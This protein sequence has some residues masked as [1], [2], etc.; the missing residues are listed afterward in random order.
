MS[1]S[2]SSQEDQPTTASLLESLNSNFTPSTPHVHKFR[3]EMCKN[4]EMY[5]K[6]K[7]GNECS[8]AHDKSQL[9]VKTQVSVLYK[10]KLCKNFSMNGYCPY[11][12]RC[13]FIHEVAEK[14]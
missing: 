10:T 11:G 9:M 12:M 6:C 1:A 8:Y 13:Q 4:W 5:G 3:T 2:S 14:K 7:F